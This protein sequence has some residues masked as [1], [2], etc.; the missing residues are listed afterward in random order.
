MLTL[1]LRCCSARWASRAPS[2]PMGT[3]LRSRPFASGLVRWSNSAPISPVSSDSSSTITV[4]DKEYPRDDYTNVTPS[5][6]ARTQRRLHLNPAHPLGILTHII[7]DHFPHFK[8][9]DALSPVVSTHANFDSLLFPPDHPGRSR[10]DAYYVNRTT[11]LRS[12]TSAHEVEVMRDHGHRAFFV[13]ADVYRRDEIDA[14]HYPVFHQIEGVRTFSPT[15]LSDGTL[16]REIAEMQ[17]FI[18]RTGITRTSEEPAVRDNPPRL[19]PEHHSARAADVALVLEHLKTSLNY[20]VAAIFS[21]IAHPSSSSSSSSSSAS[22]TAVAP[23]PIEVRWIEGSFPHTTPSF[24]IEIKYQGQWLEV[25]GCGIIQQAMLKAGGISDHIGWAVG[26]GLERLAMVLFNIPD[27]RL[28]WSEDPRFLDQ[29]QPGRINRFVPYSK[30]PPCLKDISF[31]LPEPTH[32]T[33]T[34]TDPDA[35]AV[36]GTE[37]HENDFMELV[38]EIAQDLVEDVKLVDSFK[39]PKTGRMSH[40]YRIVYRS[41]DRSVTNEEINVIQEEVRTRVANQLGLAL[42]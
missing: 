42:R 23:E 2:V 17:A 7:Y 37:F 31:W 32:P 27:I 16:T 29:F 36:A 8:R 25:C 19:Q 38:R 22:T 30:Y 6:L 15:E 33:A 14:T 13:A 40:C 28:F 3:T 5:I 1:S 35:T 21:R 39:H 41:M 10:H 24:E 4:F 20:W 11:M 12:H 18:D 9:H 26:F 34:T